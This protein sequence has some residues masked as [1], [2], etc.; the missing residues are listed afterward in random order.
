[1]KVGAWAGAAVASLL[2]I[3][4][5]GIAAVGGGA[6]ATPTAAREGIKAGAAVPAELLPWIDRNVALCPDDTRPAL[7]AAQLWAESKFDPRAVS[8]VGAQGIAQFMPGSWGQWGRDDDRNGTASPWDIGDA[9]M[10][11]G[12]YMCSL[13]AQAR[14]SPYPGGHVAL[15]LA[16]YNAGWYRVQQYHGVPPYR[17]TVQYIADITQ[18]AAEWADGIGPGDVTGTGPGAD[19]VRRAAQ[20]VGVPYVYGGGTPAGPSRGFCA[21]SNGYVDG[22]C[23]AASHEGYDCSSL[24]QAGWWPTTHLPRTAG[25]QYTATSGRPVSMDALQPGDLIFYSHGAPS[26]AYHVVMYYGAGKIIEA[27][28]S[29]KHVQIVALYTTGGMVGATRPV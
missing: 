9:I 15:A 4:V 16:G 22:V 20:Y 12:R 6:G 27:P 23:F 18:K 11:N 26:A 14:R 10:A 29:G 8:P 3:A 17:E 5:L 21:G 2:L 24:V 25:E 19:A 28:R 1:V 13:Y 7:V